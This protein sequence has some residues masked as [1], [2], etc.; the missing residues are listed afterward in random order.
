MAFVKISPKDV[1]QRQFK[2][3]FT[4][5]DPEEVGAYMKSV[6]AELERQIEQNARLSDLIADLEKS[7]PS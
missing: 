7:S 6:A 3:G 1:R 4:G 5:F 2:K